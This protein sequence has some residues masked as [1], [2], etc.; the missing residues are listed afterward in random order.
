MLIAHKIVDGLRG[1]KKYTMIKGVPGVTEAMR[2]E[3]ARRVVA[4]EKFDFGLLPLDPNPTEPGHW[5]VP[6]I[7]ADEVAWWREG[8][9]PLP[10]PLCYFEFTMGG[11]RTAFL[12]EDKGHEWT[13][14]RLDLADQ[15]VLYD[16]VVASLKFSKPASATRGSEV[17]VEVGGNVTALAWYK[18]QKIEELS[19]QYYADTAALPV[20]MSMMINSRTTEKRV[21]RVSKTLNASRVRRGKAPLSDHLV[22]RIVPERFAT[23]KDPTTGR[24]HRAP[25]L[26]WRRSHARHYDHQTPSAR[27]SETIVHE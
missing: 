27:W 2:A 11:T 23:E 16:G 10:A 24:T 13:I 12:V 8:L 18:A 20:Y 25:R 7:T 19:A 26:H 22:V 15:G 9:L 17:E 14:E 4:A 1:S 3:T 5:I 6:H 21:E